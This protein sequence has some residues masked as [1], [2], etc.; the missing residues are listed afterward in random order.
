MIATGLLCLQT[1]SADVQRTA[2][3]IDTDPACNFRFTHDVDDCW[4]LLLALEE[5]SLDIRGISSVFGNTNES[6][7]HETLVRMLEVFA[8]DDPSPPVYS[9]ADGPIDTLAAPVSTRNPAS[10]AMAAAL[11]QE[12]LTII[13][14]GPL[15]NVAAL[16]SSYPQRIA[17][18][19]RVI[20]VAGQRPQHSARIFPGESRLFHVH[21]FNFRKDVRAT[22]IVLHS[23]IPI[24]LLPFEAAQQIGIGSSELATLAEG[25]QRSHWLS[26]ISAPWLRF[27]NVAFK[28]KNFHPFDTLAVGFVSWPQLFSCQ[29]MTAW[30]EFK[31]ALFVDSRDRLLVAHATQSGSNGKQVSYCYGVSQSFKTNLIASLR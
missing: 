13:A 20:A 22:E 2:V 16:V 26:D 31:K 15:T 3:W 12:P 19:T 7:S 10:E 28:A 11:A 27:W 30:I 6:E 4:A 8:R 29:D 1:A 14:L 9:G 21:D 17:N 24:T 18:I 5:D 25:S 23:S